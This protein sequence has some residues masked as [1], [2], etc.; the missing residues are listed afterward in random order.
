[1][2]KQTEHTETPATN[3]ASVRVTPEELAAALAH[4]DAGRDGQDGK[5]AIGR[6]VEELS[7]DAAPE[8]ILRAVEAA[9]QQGAR[10]RRSRR[11]RLAALLAG[12]V[13]VGGLG[14]AKWALSPRPAPAASIAAPVRTLSALGNEQQAYVDTP[15]LIQAIHGAPA[16]QGKIYPDRTGIRWGI[17][18]HDGKVYVQAYSLQTSEQ[19]LKENKT[20]DLPLEEG[21]TIAL[22]NAEDADI[23]GGEK[24]Y[25]VFSPTVRVPDSK[26]T[27]PIHAFQYNNAQ[28]SENQ[29]KIMVSAIHPD[30]YL[31]DNFEHN[32]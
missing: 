10:R 32:H 27:L 18:K 14:T 26:L 30:D 9:R 6:A 15:G 29:A 4:L 8:D 7:L 13:A 5:I 31:W 20:V 1:M 24:G 28:Q 16:A 23:V 2:L 11:R 21:N 25:I 19:R 22:H 3:A 12:L 17:I